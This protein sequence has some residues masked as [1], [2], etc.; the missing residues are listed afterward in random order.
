MH[1]DHGMHMS[2]SDVRLLSRFIATY[3][4]EVSDSVTARVVQLEPV[5]AE[6]LFTTQLIALRRPSAPRAAAV[7]LAGL[8]VTIVTQ[9]RIDNVN[10]AALQVGE[11]K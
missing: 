3:D 10:S 2:D 4:G 1:N 5:I 9:E 7:Q 6:Q 11:R 8:R